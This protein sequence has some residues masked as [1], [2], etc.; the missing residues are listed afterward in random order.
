MSAQATLPP[1]P[2]WSPELPT[3]TGL[4]VFAQL[5]TRPDFVQHY[6]HPRVYRVSYD[7]RRKAL[8]AQVNHADTRP[9][10]ALRGVWLKVVDLPRN[11]IEVTS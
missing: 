1:P 3:K 6:A 8:V 4:W 2:Q 9:L 5:I 11:V 7:K 10:S